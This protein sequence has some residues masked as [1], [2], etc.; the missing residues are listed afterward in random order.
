VCVCVCLCH[1]YGLTTSK[2]Q[3]N[4]CHIPLL[5][6]SN[7]L[8][9]GCVCVHACMCASPLQVNHIKGSGLYL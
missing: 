7:L 2:D 6:S 9:R 4:I 8:A 1:C 3:V 5:T